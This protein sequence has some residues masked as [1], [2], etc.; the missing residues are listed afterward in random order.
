MDCELWQAQEG[1]RVCKDDAGVSKGQPAR[2]SQL[3]VEP[4]IQE[5][6]TVDLDPGLKPPTE[7]VV[8]FGLSLKPGSRYGRRRCGPRSWW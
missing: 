2:K 5:R 1:A 8:G 7:P 6:T 4:G 3:P